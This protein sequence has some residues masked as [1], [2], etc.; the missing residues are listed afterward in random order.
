MGDHHQP[1]AARSRMARSVLVAIGDSAFADLYRDALAAAGWQVEV[2]NDWRSTQERLV[3]SLP[4][5]LV[6][7]SLRDLKSVDALEHIRSHPATRELAV[8]LLMDT[9]DTVDLKRAEDL[10]VLGLLTKS[11]FT[12]ETIS[13]TI[14][15]LLNERSEPSTRGGGKRASRSI[16][17]A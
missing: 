1:D 7:N 14:S 3:N 13:E 15:R 12:R 4:D 10:G 5:V 2:A 11:R 9:V 17:S 16:G 8:I 6:L